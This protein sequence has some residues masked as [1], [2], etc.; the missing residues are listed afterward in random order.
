MAMENEMFSITF[1]VCRKA[2]PEICWET[3]PLVG[4]HQPVAVVTPE[5]ANR[6]EAKVAG[7]TA[8]PP[9]VRGGDFPADFQ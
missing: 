1:T 7:V 6:V 8:D 9:I 3:G 5:L 2:G 4:A